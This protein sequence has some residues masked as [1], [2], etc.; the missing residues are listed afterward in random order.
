VGDAL[1]IVS[2]RLAWPF[3]TRRLRARAG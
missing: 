2:R 3:G 1:G